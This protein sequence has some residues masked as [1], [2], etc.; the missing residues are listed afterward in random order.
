MA[1][2]CPCS[3][4]EPK[5]VTG[6]QYIEEQRN[7]I[8]RFEDQPMRNFR[9]K[10]WPEP[11]RYKRAGRDA[12]F[13]P[14]RRILVPADPEEDVRQRLVTYLQEELGVPLD[15]LDTEF[16]LAR[17][18]RGKR[19]RADVVGSVLT[20]ELRVPLFLVECKR[21]DVMLVDAD[22]EQALGYDDVLQVSS[23]V[24]VLTNGER[25]EWYQW[26]GDEWHEIEQIP[27]FNDMVAGAKLK[28]AAEP[29][30]PPRVAPGKPSPADIQL[31]RD[32][33]V[34]GED[35]PVANADYVLNLSGLIYLETDPQ[36]SGSFGRYRHIAAGAR[37]TQ[38]GN[39]GGGSWSGF[40][41]YFV[42][43]DESDEHQVVSISIMAKASLRNDPHWGNSTGNTMLL[44]AID[45]F[46][47]SH[48]S[49][50]LNLDKYVRRVG[51]EIEIWH[52]GRLTRGNRGAAKNADVIAFVAQHEPS[53]V[54]GGE[55]LL[56]RLPNDR[57][58]R[59]D[60][61]QDFVER[62]IRYAFV[63][64]AFRDAF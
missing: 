2:V 22:L 44:V 62:C 27:S 5:R 6:P 14:C 46:E 19:G 49:L 15:M 30:L 42:V 58:V 23:G 31:Y 33:G 21:P 37:E 38:F 32:F 36:Y 17:I 52:D 53:L 43:A 26:G 12:F 54:V 10:D 40:Y 50:Q 34:F 47:K 60:D 11:K 18:E 24:V 64:D 63:R 41:R 13:D 56:G 29:P 4:D 35:S 45:N 59:W 55:V 51:S 25:T 8:D 20:D 48:N 1:L 57:L 7:P 9:L 3:G 61:A 28:H 16:H 39:A